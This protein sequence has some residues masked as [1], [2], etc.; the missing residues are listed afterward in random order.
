MPPRWLRGKNS[1]DLPTTTLETSP[2]LVL[3]RSET[4]E[5]VAECGP[6]AAVQVFPEGFLNEI[7]V[8]ISRDRKSVV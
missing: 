8:F 4:Q 3:K 1:V 7:F 6:E 2:D 5:R